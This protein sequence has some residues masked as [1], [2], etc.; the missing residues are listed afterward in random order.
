[1]VEKHG[2][3]TMEVRK[4]LWQTISDDIDTTHNAQDHCD[5]LNRCSMLVHKWTS[6]GVQAKNVVG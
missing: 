2:L 4:A 6:E 1:M 3:G 5:F